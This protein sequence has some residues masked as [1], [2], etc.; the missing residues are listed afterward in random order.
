[1]EDDEYKKNVSN[2]SGSGCRDIPYKFHCAV[3][4]NPDQLFDSEAFIE[5]DC[6]CR[7]CKKL[8]VH[9]YVPTDILNSV[10][11]NSMFELSSLLDLNRR[12]SGYRNAEDNPKLHYIKD[13]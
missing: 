9:E 8:F 11:Y 13:I 6:E 10:R 1:M 2:R 12:K 3:Q 4:F 5:R 7:L